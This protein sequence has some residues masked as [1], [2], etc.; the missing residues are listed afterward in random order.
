VT[1]FGAWGDHER[2]WAEVEPRLAWAAARFAPGGHTVQEL[3][4]SGTSGDLGY[5][6]SIEHGTA[7]VTGASEAVPMRLRVTH[8][9]RREAGEWKL[10]HR[11][12][13]AVT[14]KIPAAA[15]LSPA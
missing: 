9:Y 5:T 12:A 15:V 3:L 11:H 14:A 8:I 6:V 10:V 2:G 4:A 1:I 13:D 7:T